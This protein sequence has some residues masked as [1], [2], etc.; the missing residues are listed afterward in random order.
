MLR[1]QFQR[2]AEPFGGDQPDLGRLP[3]DDRL[4][5]ALADLY[6][7]FLDDRDQAKQHLQAILALAPGDPAP[8]ITLPAVI[9]KDQ[10]TGVRNVG[11]YRM[12]K[13]DSRS[14]A[15]H[16]QLHKDGRMDYLA[17]DGRRS[18]IIAARRRGSG[19][20]GPSAQVVASASTLF[21][22]PNRNEAAMP[23]ISVEDT[24]V[25]PRISTPDPTTTTARPVAKVVKAHHAVEGAG[26][27]VWRPFPGGIDAHVAD[28]F[29]LLDQLGPVEYAPNEPVLQDGKAVFANATHRCHLW[30]TAA[31]SSA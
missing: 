30:S 5:R 29:F 25:L 16:W 24:L 14:T 10:A 6:R 26:F 1:P 13:L 3:L 21:A 11:M 8:F 22:G 23:A 7:N 4:H 31:A 17:T 28:P 15:M 18:C 19:N 9:T 12:Q 20:P 2:V 27:E